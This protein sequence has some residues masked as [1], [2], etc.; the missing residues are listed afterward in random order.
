ML[1][2][3]MQHDVVAVGAS[4][5]GVKAL[6][7]LVGSLPP[8]LPAAVFVALHL[9][10][11]APRVLPDALNRAASM[12]A[13]HAADHERIVP[14]RIY[15]APPDAD[16]RIETGRIRLVARRRQEGRP[17]AVDLL[18]RSAAR[19]YG[20]RTVG[21]VLTG[22]L[23]D[24]TAGLRAVKAAGGVAVVQDPADAFCGIMPSNA[25]GMVD[26]DHCLPLADIGPLLVRLARPT[27]MQPPEPADVDERA[28][29]ALWAAVRAMESRANFLR[30]LAEHFRERRLPGQVAYFEECAVEAEGHAAVLRALMAS[31]T[32][33]CTPA[34]A[35]AS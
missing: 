3:E 30:D 16:L 27:D 9:S 11:S 17:T 8:D 22:A 6:T 26:V 14:G 19:A 18:F 29:R 23:S 12:P 4:A 1:D 13:A 24:G 20:S 28:E 7:R 31:G 33:S 2:V 32:A 35:Q 10:P 21:V 5:G 25:K 34:R 15:V